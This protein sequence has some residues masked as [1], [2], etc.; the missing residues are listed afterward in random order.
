M[1]FLFFTS[2]K[3]NLGPTQHLIQWVPG[4]LF[5]GVER[6]KGQNFTVIVFYFS[7]RFVSV[8]TECIVDLVPHCT[9]SYIPVSDECKLFDQYL[10]CYT[11]IHT[12]K[13]L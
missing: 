9:P 11:K 7:H 6:I 3:P 1:I 12:E 5:L 8:P 2:S 4:A 13:P 10:A